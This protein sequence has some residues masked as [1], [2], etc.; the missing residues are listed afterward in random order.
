M[1]RSKENEENL[2]DHTSCFNHRKKQ[3][4]SKSLTPR[5]NSCVP[6]CVTMTMC[7]IWWTRPSRVL[8][9]WMPPSRNRGQTRPADG[10]GG[11]EC[12]RQPGFG[13]FA[14]WHNP[15]RPLLVLISLGFR[16]C[17]Q[18]HDQCTTH[19]EARQ[20]KAPSADKPMRTIETAEN[21]P[22]I[23]LRGKSP[24]QVL[25]A[26]ALV[27]LSS[28]VRG[29]AADLKPETLQAWESYLQ[30]AKARN[31]KHLTDGASFLSIDDDP[32]I[33]AKLRHG[34][35]I[36]SPARPNVPIKVPSGLIHDWVGAIFIPN[37]SI[38]DV[39]RVVRDYDH[40]QAIYHPNVVA[41]KTIEAGESKDRFSMVLMNKSFFAKSA[42]DSDYRSTC[43]RVDDQH[44]YSTSETT[45]VQEAAE[46]GAASQHLLPEGHGKGIIWRL[47]SFAHYEERDGGVYIELEAI[48]LSRD[49]PAT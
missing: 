30:T 17:T 48:A 26:V 37:A 10:N 33:S 6:M 39:M 24:L 44:W 27:M 25:A 7:V 34:G 3:L 20:R 4:N 1:S 15:A 47:Y 49:I 40:Y 14:L 32:A 31:Q 45:R 28:P 21:R 18:W 22:A 8:V 11:Q 16:F 23:A 13:Q 5:R 41:S 36:V 43:V 42:L 12:G 46:Y 38:G 2:D 9:V 35:I 19:C 29:A